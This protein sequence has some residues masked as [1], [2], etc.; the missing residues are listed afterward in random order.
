MMVQALNASKQVESITIINRPVSIYERLINKKPRSSDGLGK[1]KF[2]D[3]TSWDLIGPLKKRAWTEH[4]FD[5]VFAHTVKLHKISS[6]HQTVLLDFTPIAKID[7]QQ[8]DQTI[9]WYDLIDNFTR[10]N[11]FSQNQKQLVKEKYL[12][13]EKQAHLISGVTT[14][15]LSQFDRDD[16]LDIANGILENSASFNKK[17]PEFGFGFVGFITNKLDVDF[18]IRLTRTSNQK[19]AV[20]GHAYDAK[21]LRQLEKTNGIQCFGAFNEKDLPQIM[22]RFEVGLIPYRNSKSHDGSP[23]KLYQYFNYGRPVICTQHYEDR[24]TQNHYVCSVEPKEIE[25]AYLFFKRMRLLQQADPMNF[26]KDIQSQIDDSIL[27]GPKMDMIL[28]RLDS[29]SENLR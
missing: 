24:L 19:I 22:N 5:E 1:I 3:T 14:A 20:F 7:Y 18:L 17:K 8:F 16:T 9:V 6:K 29:L 13:V 26:L 10:H 15:A 28:S 21:I 23:I 2:V 27:W 12:Y 11:R 25:T 4:C